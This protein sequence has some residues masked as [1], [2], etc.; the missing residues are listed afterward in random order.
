MTGGAPARRLRKFRPEDAEFCFRVRS[1]A[2]VVDFMDEIGPEAVAFCVGSY[3]PA[4]FV[5]MAGK[6]ELFVVEEDAEPAGFLALG[7][8]DQRTAEIPMVYLDHRRRGR[9][10]GSWCMAAAER[11]LS[12][13]RPE[14]TKLCVDTVIPRNTEGF[15]RKLGFALE[16]ETTTDFK[17]GSLPALRF[18][19]PLRAR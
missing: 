5:R 8:A 2:F 4:D 12:E 1:R 19:K 15:Y 9:G 14:V 18:A 16:G 3:L 7:R 6:L 11:W 13:N 10:L 17:G